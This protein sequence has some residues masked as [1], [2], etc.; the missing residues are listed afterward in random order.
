M[1]VKQPWAG[2]IIRGDK[3]VENR[4]RKTNIRGR[5]AIHAGRSIDR[6]GIDF[7]AANSIPLPDMRTGE[8]IG[9]VEIIDS[10]THSDSIFFRGPHGY[11]LA[12]PA[13]CAPIPIRGMLGFFDV[14]QIQNLP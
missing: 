8:I 10:V 11:L 4:S 12:N 14:P 6:G 2:L 1:T 9:T 13:S 3:T 5:I 7:C